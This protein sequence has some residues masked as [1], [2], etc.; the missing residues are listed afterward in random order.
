MAVHCGDD[1]KQAWFQRI[2]EALDLP[3]LARIEVQ[4]AAIAA[5]WVGSARFKM[6][7]RRRVLRSRAQD[8]QVGQAGQIAFAQAY[9]LGAPD[10]RWLYRYRLSDEAF[11][12]LHEEPSHTL[13]LKD[14]KTPGPRS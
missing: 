3:A 12:R 7:D 1:E 10:G 11:A 4:L 13:D 9:G 6:I 5:L 2:D 8:A 14:C